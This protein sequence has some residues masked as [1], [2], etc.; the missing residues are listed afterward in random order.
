MSAR[1]WLSRWQEYILASA[2]RPSGNCRT[3][4]NAWISRPLLVQPRLAAFLLRRWHGALGWWHGGALPAAG[5]ANLTRGRNRRV[6]RSVRPGMTQLRVLA[7]TLVLLVAGCAA[8]STGGSPPGAAVNY[9][10][11]EPR[12]ADRR[13]RRPGPGRHDGHRGADPEH[14]RRRPGR[15]QRTHDRDLSRV[16]RCRTSRC[17]R[18][19]TSDV[20]KLA[21][22][23]VDAGVG[24]QADFGMPNVA[25]APTTHVMVRTAAGEQVTDVPALGIGEES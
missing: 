23:A 24:K 4:P 3:V 25:D 17:S 10:P 12:P 16:R 15:H 1:I 14:L 22:R 8:E 2:D 9:A 18:S 5:G 21:D 7:A 20:V 6:G 11:D 13:V 19:A